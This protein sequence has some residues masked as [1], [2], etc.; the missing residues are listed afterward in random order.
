MHPWRRLRPLLPAVRSADAR[1]LADLKRQLHTDLTTYSTTAPAEHTAEAETPNTQ[2]EA[3]VTMN[4]TY[5][6]RTERKAAAKR[7]DYIRGLVALADLLD[8][9]PDIPLPYDGQIVPGIRGLNIFGNAHEPLAKLLGR[10]NRVEARDRHLWLEW[11]INGLAVV[12]LAPIGVCEQRV[13]GIR[14]VGDQEVPVT[15]TVVP[16]RF[17]PATTESAVHA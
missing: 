13:I 15:E 17:Q 2:Q 3:G 10:P 16:E 11:H 12:A 7:S 9:N 14:K 4:L 5:A 6:E 8:A 1:V